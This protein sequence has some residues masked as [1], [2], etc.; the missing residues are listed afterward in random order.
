MFVPVTWC[1]YAM[2]ITISITTRRSNTR[3]IQ[4]CLTVTMG[5]ASL[6][7]RKP[8]LKRSKAHAVSLLY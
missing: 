8:A 1:Q 4:A 5:G 7:Q 2:K 6:P 3:P